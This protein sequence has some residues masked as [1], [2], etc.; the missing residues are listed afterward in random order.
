MHTTDDWETVVPLAAADAVTREKL[1]PILAPN[2]GGLTAPVMRP[3]YD[4]IME[5]VQP[6]SG[7]TYEADVIGGIRGWWCKPVNAP[8]DRALLHLHGG[9][10]VFGSARAYRNF[11]SNIAQRA[12]LETF[13]PDYRLAPEHPLPAAIEDVRAVYDGLIE[14]GFR[15]V[16]I[17]GDSAGGALAI[18]LGAALT[19]DTTAQV[20]PRALVLLSPVT[21]LTL[22]GAS[23]A[24]RDEADLYFTKAQV[25]ALVQMYLGAQSA[26]DAL[27]SPLYLDFCGLPSTRVYAGDDEML[28]DD[29][30][31]FVQA[32]VS[33]GV[34][35]KLEVWQ[36]MLHVFPN[37]VGTFQAADIA[38]NE[39]GEF[40]SSRSTGSEETPSRSAR[41]RRD[42]ERADR[43]D[44]NEEQRD[45]GHHA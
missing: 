16:A 35:A 18:E 20:K 6:A 1:R 22:S 8:T 23:W 37:A 38:L 27:A 2:K 13:I 34:D 10:F 41:A 26:T 3:D 19:K 5:H 36:G 17:S 45:P 9:W 31:R 29:S 24:T 42:Q 44:A 14:R 11:V 21:D 30:R 32:A 12:T 15:D 28:L 39:I 4:A 7:V 40:L 33:A 25:Q 43:R